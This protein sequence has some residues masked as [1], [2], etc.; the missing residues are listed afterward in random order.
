LTRE[1]TRKRKSER[2]RAMQI[3]EQKEKAERDPLIFNL[4]E[5]SLKFDNSLI[6]NKTILN[7]NIK[8][9]VE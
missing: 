9:S 4:R 6:A 3:D 1:R 7:R 8:P 5:F 2:D